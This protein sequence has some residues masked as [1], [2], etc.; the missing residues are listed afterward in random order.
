MKYVTSFLNSSAPER[1]YISSKF[2]KPHTFNSIALYFNFSYSREDV[3]VL[4][5]H[6]IHFVLQL[7]L[8]ASLRLAVVEALLLEE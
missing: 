2:L 8:R 3:F 1:K 7:V 6:L 4:S 5:R